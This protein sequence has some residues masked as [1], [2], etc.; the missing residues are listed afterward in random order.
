LSASVR[1]ELRY[2]RFF[3]SDALHALLSFVIWG[4]VAYTLVE[5]S[6][7]RVAPA[8]IPLVCVLGFMPFSRVILNLL[9][10][11]ASGLRRLLFR[12]AS[13]VR[14]ELSRLR[15]YAIAAYGLDFFIAVLMAATG[16]VTLVPQLAASALVSTELAVLAGVLLSFYVF[17]EKE[18]SYRYGQ[19]LQSKSVYVST[20]TLA[21]IGGSVYMV[22]RF[23]GLFSLACAAGAILYV[24][25]RWLP[26]M[27]AAIIARRGNHLL[28]VS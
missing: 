12:P 3:T 1:K 28:Q 15:A 23:G 7:R 26:E 4:F 2:H 18:M 17:E 19:H 8:A 5:G 14:Y 11:D 25:I 16:S 9:G 24:N 22:G 6:F 10:M 20:L 27:A 13:L 21:A